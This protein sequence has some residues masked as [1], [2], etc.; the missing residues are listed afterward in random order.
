[1]VAFPLD[2]E[3]VQSSRDAILDQA[4]YR[5]MLAV[6]HTGDNM[7]NIRFFR[8]E[9]YKRR[10]SVPGPPVEVVEFYSY[11]T[12]VLASKNDSFLTMALART[13]ATRA[14]T[15]F[16]SERAVERAA[17][18]R[19]AVGLELEMNEA[20]R[21]STTPVM[22]YLRVVTQYDL[23]KDSRWKLVNVPL[24]NGLVYLS[25]N[26]LQDLF[27]ALVQGLMVSGIRAIRSA[28]VPSFMQSLVDE[29]KVRIPPPPPRKTNSYQYIQ[30]LLEYPIRDGRHRVIWLILTPYFVNVKGLDEAAATDAVLSYIGETKYKRF[31]RYY[32]K[33][34][35]KNGLLPPSE[36]SLRS[37]HPD[38]LQVLP[39]DIFK[40]EVLKSKPR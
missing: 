4:R 39:K 12:A 23:M 31:V 36:E 27:A 40:S 17:V 15:F 21:M 3:T 7:Q 10:N 22:S 19:E 11:F 13:E 24:G 26:M 33:R 29:M 18:L 35:I 32:V 28:P 37:K 2:D 30:R 6:K 25:T 1:M 5:L 34:A 16:L 38:I 8:Y 14:K 9:P 20:R